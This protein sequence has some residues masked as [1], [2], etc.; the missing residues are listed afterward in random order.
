VKSPIINTIGAV[1][2]PVSNMTRAIEW[3][4]DL[5]DLPL[6]ET[7]HEGTIYDLPMAGDTAL[8]LDANEKEVTNSSQPLFFF[9]TEDMAASYAFLNDKQIEII[10]Q[11]EAIG[12]VSFLT[13]KDPDNNLLMVCERK[14]T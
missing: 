7:S 6:L 11:V 10:G 9:M 12:S 4:S 14:K 2:I 5:L 1:F 8:I 13:F 3:Y